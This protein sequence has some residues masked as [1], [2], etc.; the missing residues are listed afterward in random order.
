MAIGKRCSIK[1]GDNVQ[2]LDGDGFYIRDRIMVIPK[3]ATIP[4]DTII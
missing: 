2:E 4:D 3:N 1:N